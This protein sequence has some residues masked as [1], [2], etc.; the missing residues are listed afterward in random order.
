MHVRDLSPRRGL[1]VEV[2]FGP[3]YEALVGLVAFAGDEPQ[4]SYEVGREWFRTAR[5]QASADLV[6]GLRRLVGRTGWLMASFTALVRRGP[7]RTIGDLLGRLEAEDAQNVKELLVAQALAEGEKGRDLRRLQAADAEE[8]KRLSVLVLERWQREVFSAQEGE[9][10]PVLEA[11]ARV[12]Q[13]QARRVPALHLVEQATNG[14]A[15]EA[16]PGITTVVL[17]PSVLTRPWVLITESGPEKIFFC[18]APAGERSERRLAALYAALG[19]PSR[20]RILRRLTQGEAGLTELAEELGLAK[21]TV[22]GHLVLLRDAGM[23][24]ALV[25]A[26]KGYRLAEPRPQLDHPLADYL[27]RRS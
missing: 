25:G 22:H 11:Q 2:D 27:G 6:D 21:S 26:R 15:Y 19:D 5:R 17:I 20:L 16:E 1:R 12:W 3:A 7:G 4:V 24:R 10:L 8:V 9:L 14:I 23:V 13:R 18:P